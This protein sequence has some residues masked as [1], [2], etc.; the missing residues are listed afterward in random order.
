MLTTSFHC[1]R[2][3]LESKVRAG[4]RVLLLA[5]V[6]L[7]GSAG[8]LHAGIVPVN[9]SGALG[10]NDAVFWSQL[11]VAGMTLPNSNTLTSVNGL[12]GS[13]AQ[14]TGPQLQTNT[15]L[16]NS[17]AY[18]NQFGGPVT[19]NFNSPVFGVGVLTMND[20]GSVLPFF[21]HIQ[22]FNSGG[23]L[24][25]FNRPSSQVSNT[26][27]YV[28]VL[29]TSQEITKVVF[30][31][32]ATPSNSGNNFALDTL[33]LNRT[34]GQPSSAPEPSSFVLMGVALAAALWWRLRRPAYKR[35]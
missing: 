5:G 18:D 21:Y 14:S 16:V 1:F 13:I 29:D 2:T 27:T 34:S 11:G 4:C 17:P 12:T 8:C 15:A 20:F 35:L 26:A 31:V 28:G 24:G 25:T 33:N 3:L 22:V 10:A 7:V 19:V 30:T 6:S 23:S 9:S 32:D